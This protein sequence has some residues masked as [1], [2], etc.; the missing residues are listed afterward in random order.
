MSEKKIKARYDYWFLMVLAVM[1]YSL[2]TAMVNYGSLLALNLANITLWARVLANAIAIF[3]VMWIF[4]I[5]VR[6]VRIAAKHGKGI[7]IAG[8]FQEVSNG[9]G[10]TED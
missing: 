10:E 2:T 5:Y 6:S 4:V 8:F 3:G 1:L 7:K 9:N